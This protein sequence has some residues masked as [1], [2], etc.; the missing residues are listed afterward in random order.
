MFVS[1]YADDVGSA[2]HYALE[3]THAISVCLSTWI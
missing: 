1:Y 2:V 3:A